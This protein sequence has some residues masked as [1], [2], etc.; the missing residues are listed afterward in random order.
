MT[1]HHMLDNRLVPKQS[2]VQRRDLS[3]MTERSDC[4][5]ELLDQETLRRNFD[6]Q[7]LKLTKMLILIRS[8]IFTYLT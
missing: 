7:P 3:C 2:M 1:M 5:F 4:T 6:L 8:V